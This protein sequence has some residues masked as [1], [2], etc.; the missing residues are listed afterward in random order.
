MSSY[1]YTSPRFHLS[2]SPLIILVNN[3]PGLSL[4]IVSALPC[5]TVDEACFGAKLHLSIS[6]TITNTGFCTVLLWEHKICAFS[7]TRPVPSL[8]VYRFENVRAGSEVGLRPIP[9]GVVM[10][11]NV[12]LSRHTCKLPRRLQRALVGCP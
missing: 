8:D 10:R 5:A 12:L 11:L 4:P 1:Q 3:R 2:A 7:R 9:I 6:L